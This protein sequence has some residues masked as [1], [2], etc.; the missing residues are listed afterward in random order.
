MTRIERIKKILKKNLEP[1]YLLI[2]DQSN[3]HSGHNSFDGSNETHLYIEISSRF[4][5]KKKLI[6]SH[7]RINFLIQ[8]EYKEGLHSLEIKII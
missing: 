5:D 8:N 2:K 3:K 4:F 6:D 7:K 1:S